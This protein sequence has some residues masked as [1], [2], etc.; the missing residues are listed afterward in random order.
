MVRIRLP[1]RETW[2]QSLIWED[3]MCLR[4]TKPMCH[5]SWAGA[6]QPESWRAETTEPTHSISSRHHTPQ[7]K[8]LQWE[9]HA[10]Q[11]EIRTPLAT[12]TVHKLNSKTVCLKNNLCFW[13]P[14]FFSVWQDSW[15]EAPISLIRE[16]VRTKIPI[17]VRDYN[18]SDNIRNH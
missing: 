18:P 16:N 2:V 3:P 1:M 4:A 12:C 5:N 10:P 13:D 17:I 9:A 6:L 8:P 15:E 7:E 11:L 14:P